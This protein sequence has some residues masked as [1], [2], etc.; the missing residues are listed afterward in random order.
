MMLPEV[1]GGSGGNREEV[2]GAQAPSAPTHTPSLSLS[3][4]L[5]VLSVEKRIGSGAKN[6]NYRVPR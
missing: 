1:S 6:K 5:R 2:L 4:S 3:C